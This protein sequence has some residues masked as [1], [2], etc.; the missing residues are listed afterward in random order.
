MRLITTLA[1]AIATLGSL[2]AVAQTSAPLYIVNGQEMADVKHIPQSD[3]ES[4]EPLEINDESIA[5]YGERASNGVIIITLK[6]DTKASFE[7]GKSFEKYIAS[8]VRWDSHEPAARVILRYTVGTDGKVAIGDIIESTDKR[9]HR[10]VLAAIAEAP[11]WSPA[12]RDG[13]SIESDHVL[14]IRLPEGKQMPAEPY[15]RI[16]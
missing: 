5:R 6:Y 13:K 8:Q 2:L 4:I 7:G 14:D 12:T 16:L 11:K 1:T 15:I 3:I 10:R 9:L